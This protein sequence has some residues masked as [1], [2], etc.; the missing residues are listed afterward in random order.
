MRWGSVVVGSL[1]VFAAR[2]T[3]A[4]V[5]V[6]STR[7]YS[8]AWVRGNGAEHCP[9]ASD[10][11]RDV[12]NRIGRPL[13]DGT[14]AQSI[15]VSVYRDD[16]TTPPTHR[17]EIHVRDV[18]G[19]SLFD[20]V[21]SS[22]EEDCRPLV[23][24]TA[25][26]IALLVDPDATQARS[27]SVPQR[28][29]PMSL[30]TAIGAQQFASKVERVPNLAAFE[31]AAS[32]A[33]HQQTPVQAI[34]IPGATAANPSPF[35]APPAS[36]ADAMASSERVS[37]FSLSAVGGVSLVPQPT[38]GVSMGTRA[39]E[40]PNLGW[41]ISALYLSTQTADAIGATRL[42]L[43]LTALQ[44]ALCLELSKNDYV[45]MLVDLGMSF[46]VLHLALQGAP[47]SFRHLEYPF[48]AA[49]GELEAQIKVSKHMY[50]GLSLGAL[51]PLVR[52]R[53]RD[54]ANRNEVLFV[55]PAIGAVSRIG[56]GMQF[57]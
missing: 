2:S 32:A 28:A 8:L 39:W 36:R 21:L 45:R 55:Q 6:A 46:G 19:K 49:R 52:Q 26:T 30:P 24:S 33:P 13:F 56:I 10:L 57:P 27:A 4:D 15:E 47:A 14:A 17:S 31:P 7:Y 42:S 11:Q 50:L 37:Q 18:D 34:S 20:R 53:F 12:E 22:D 54:A 44:P 25:L 23:A 1:V 3:L 29:S 5:H 48:V 9:S 16:R 35:P 43:G 38:F 41:S 40:L 51:V